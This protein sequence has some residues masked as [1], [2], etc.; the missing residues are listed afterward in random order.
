MTVCDKCWGDGRV[1][2]CSTCNG[3]GKVRGDVDCK[4]CKGTGKNKC[5]ECGGEGVIE[6]SNGG[7]YYNESIIIRD[8]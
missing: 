8:L 2:K 6:N 7:A 5:Q 4:S 1:G 3:C